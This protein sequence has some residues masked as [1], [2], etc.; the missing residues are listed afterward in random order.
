MYPTAELCR[1][2]Q[3]FH[4]ERARTTQL[5]N[6]RMVAEKA[7]KAWGVEADIAEHREARRVQVRQTADLIAAQRQ[8]AGVEMLY[9]PNENP[10]RGLSPGPR[11]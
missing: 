6:V 10:D 4:R 8:Q 2:Q 7:A 9:C 3:A 1:S 11:P 5:E